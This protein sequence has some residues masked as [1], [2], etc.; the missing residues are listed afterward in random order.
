MIYCRY[1]IVRFILLLALFIS[2]C[3]FQKSIT[4]DYLTGHYRNFGFYSV[5]DL[6]LNS[7]GICTYESITKIGN[8]Q[9]IGTWKLVNGKLILNCKKNIAFSDSIKYNLHSFESGA[10]WK[11]GTRRTS[12][13]IKLD[14]T[15]IKTMDTEG[16]PFSSIVCSVI[17][18]DSTYVE[19]SNE[20]GYV[21]IQYNK[22]IESIL[23]QYNGDT[24]GIHYPKI[25]HN[26]IYFT[27]RDNSEFSIFKNTV[28]NVKRNK[29][30]QISKHGVKNIYR[31]VQ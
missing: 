20:N 3:G 30:I 4:V 29:L 26:Y 14:Q 1:G 10:A 17:T 5:N 31:K 27:I 21:I 12:K 13:L 23:L 22:E 11:T 9:S 8:Q 15:I 2:G 25:G 6:Y 16:F 28:F 7:D 24:I 19:T 18:P